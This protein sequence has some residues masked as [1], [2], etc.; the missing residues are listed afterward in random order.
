[1]AKFS[2]KRHEQI[3]SS[4]IARIVARSRLSDVADTSVWK[5]TAAASSRQDDEQYYQM[6]LLLALFS[7]DRASGD[8][9]DERAKDIQPGVVKRVLASEA[10]GTVV[11]TR[12]GT[13]GSVSI[14]I[15]TKVKT[16]AGEIF[17]TTTTG[18]ITPT[19]VE[20]ISSNGV[21]RDSNLVS[22]VADEAGQSGNVSANTVVKFENKP[23]GID[24]VTN[25]VSFANGRDKETD[26]SFRTRL[27]DFVRGLARCTA[28]AIEAG[29][30]GQT[31]SVSG[32]TIL[33]A[34]VTEDPIL[35]GNVTAFIDDGTGQAEA[36]SVTAIQL[37]AVFTWNGTLTVTTPDTSE[38]ISG[39][40]IRLNSDGQWFEVNVVTVDTNV[41]ILNP[42]SDVIPT[43]A[44]A[45]S[46][47]SDILTEG[48]DP[49]DEAVGGETTLFLD[50][51]PI[52]DDLPINIAT[53]VAGNLVSPTDYTL[54]PASG[55]VE[56]VTPLVVGEQVVAGYT[57]F[58][59]LIA[60]TQKVIDGDANDR[61]NFPGFRAAG[62][63]VRAKVP[64]ILVQPVT[65]IV[66]V[67]EG[68]DQSD[69]IADTIQA[70]K[71]YVN[72]L[73][74]SGDVLRAELFSFI[75]AVEG[76]TNVNITVPADDVIILDDQLAR[77]QDSSITVT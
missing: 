63:L 49:F 51:F 29:I 75:M 48:F 19:S 36:I 11:F 24:E 13:A 30:V 64:Q 52:K 65:A 27:K 21:G 22:V 42:G 60:F 57:N 5:H 32:A 44:T 55:Q 15:G 9:L 18:T 43:G 20:Q 35:R 10:T 56:L 12:V 31:D 62:V 7:I 72:T 70:I 1:M 59:G 16:A 74:I 58:T 77:T 33:F 40:W 50:N 37:S 54:N 34:K 46:K 4:Q 39:D 69:V 41:T 26:P 3:Y 28:Q 38:V 45:S 17:T 53:D 71:D 8:D 6:S 68:F 47:N 66:T 67:T 23:A 14:I 61:T 2:P 73:T 25:T 76:V